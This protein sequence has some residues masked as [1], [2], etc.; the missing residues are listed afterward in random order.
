MD[1]TE[2]IL[3]SEEKGQNTKVQLF[4]YSIQ[5][6]ISFPVTYDFNRYIVSTY[7]N[8]DILMNLL[9]KIVL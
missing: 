6:V 1:K 7:I 5:I 9:N 3:R 4:I 2:K 8:I